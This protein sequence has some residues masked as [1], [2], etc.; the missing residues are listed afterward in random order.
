M[1]DLEKKQL[2]NLK[3][4]IV[5]DAERRKEKVIAVDAKTFKDVKGK[6]I[7]LKLTSELLEKMKKDIEIIRSV[8]DWI[9]LCNIWRR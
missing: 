7:R 9:L 3:K 2:I 6:E 4:A 8:D 5:E 1:N